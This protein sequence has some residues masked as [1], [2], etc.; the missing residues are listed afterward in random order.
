MSD[1]D[2]L[3]GD[4]HVSNRRLGELFVGSTEWRE[5]E[6]TSWAR[7]LLGG[8]GNVDEMDCPSEGFSGATIRLQDQASGLWS[9]YWADSTSGRLFPPVVGSFADGRGDFY[10][11]D[12]VDGRPIRAH[13][14]WSRITP[15]SARWEQE[16]SM[17]DGVTWETNWVME[18]S[19][20]S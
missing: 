5:F 4:W 8:V 15:D 18:F 16:F 10:G 3:Y 6:A 14:I 9:I 20:R 12:Q 2:F 1:F 11:D 7:P 13:F 17:D 19:R